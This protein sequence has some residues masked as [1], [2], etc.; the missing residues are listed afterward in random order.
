[1]RAKGLTLIEMIIAAVVGVAILALVAA[2]L[3]SGSESLRFVQNAQLLTEDLRNAGN[4][5]SD[6]V[7]TAAF[8]YPPG[9]TLSI[10]T[11]GGY[12]VRNPSRSDN[13]WRIGRDPAIALLQPPTVVDGQEVVRFVMV[14]PLNRGW[15]VRRASGAENPGPD[16]ANDGKWLLYIYERNLPVGAS[17]LPNGLPTTIPT[18]IPGS[19]GNLLADYLQPGGFVVAYSDCLAFD[20]AGWAVQAPCPQSPPTPLRAEHSAVRVSFSLQGE[21]HQGGR[22]TRIP[23]QPLRFE[24]APRNLPK[25]QAEV[26]P[27]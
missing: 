24:A 4:L 6:L 21:V 20:E 18:E 11:P 10:G 1:M 25:R 19:S 8:V 23:G 9:V 13:L 3:R 27:N 5:V 2:G 17:R 12:T 22:D 26:S 14:Y 16:P 15:V 7:A